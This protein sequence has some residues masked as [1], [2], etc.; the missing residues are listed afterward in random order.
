MGFG[1]ERETARRSSLSIAK[2]DGSGQV[3]ETQARNIVYSRNYGLKVHL[4]PEIRV[5]MD[6]LE[7]VLRSS[8]WSLQAATEYPIRSC[9]A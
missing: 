9:A 3:F 8:N 6:H 7:N 1:R 5:Q 4:N 2:R